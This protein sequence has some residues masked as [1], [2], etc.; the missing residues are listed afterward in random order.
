MVLQYDMYTQIF[1]FSLCVFWKLPH[2]KKKQT[3]RGNWKKD[4][5]EYIHVIG[6]LL[7]SRKG[8][9]H[10]ELQLVEQPQLS[11]SWKSF[12]D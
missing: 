6:F 5:C 12:S 7:S 2:E 1:Y 10:D 9:E 4:A 8:R 3:K 11:R